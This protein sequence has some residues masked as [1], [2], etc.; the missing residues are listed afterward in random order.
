MTTLN[1]TRFGPVW[2]LA[3]HA[4]PLETLVT[5]QLFTVNPVGIVT[6]TVPMRVR[7][8]MTVIEMSVG[9]SW[10]SVIGDADT[11]QTVGSTALIGLVT[12][13]ARAVAA[14]SATAP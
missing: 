4:A 1:Q 6:R 5:L 13:S 7:P 2:K 10:V 14:T 9:W 8:P 3:D 12:R 11:S